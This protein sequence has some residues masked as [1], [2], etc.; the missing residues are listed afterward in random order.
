[1]DHN[2]KITKKFTKKFGSKVIDRQLFHRMTV[3]HMK[4]LS[5]INFT[6]KLLSIKDQF[7]KGPNRKITKMFTKK[8]DSKA[9]IIEN[10]FIERIEAIL[11]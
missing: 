4:I 7:I 2:R 1:M 10:I 9:K 5:I 3:F 11:I 6:N 8:F